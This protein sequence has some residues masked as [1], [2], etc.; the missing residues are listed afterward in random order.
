MMLFANIDHAADGMKKRV[1][2]CQLAGNVD[3]LVAQF[4]PD[5]FSK[6]LPSCEPTIGRCIPL[7]GGAHT[8]AIRQIEIIPHADLIAVI[9]DWRARK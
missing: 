4:T 8:V 3:M 1:G 7:H 9:D 2:V 5:Q 6:G